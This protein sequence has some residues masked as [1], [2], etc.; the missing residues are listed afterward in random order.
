MIHVEVTEK[1]QREAIASWYVGSCH[2]HAM[3]A[4][5]L[6]RRDIRFGVPVVVALVLGALVAGALIGVNLP[7][8]SKPLTVARGTAYFSSAVGKGTFQTEDESVSALILPEVGWVDRSGRGEF[9]SVPSC[10]R[11]TGEPA[12]AQASVEAAYTRLRLPEGR[13]MTVVAWIRCL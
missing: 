12:A 8:G 9:F 7:F 10:L 11:G 3:A 6:A 1:I 4:H 2:D 13:S 5:V